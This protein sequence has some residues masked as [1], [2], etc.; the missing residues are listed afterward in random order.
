MV[1]GVLGLIVGVAAGV[2]VGRQSSSKSAALPPDTI[3]ASNRAPVIPPSS[4][5]ALR[6]RTNAIPDASASGRLTVE[7]LPA[8]IERVMRG[9]QMDRYHALYEL[10]NRVEPV[11]IPRALELLS[12]HSS[13]EVR[14]GISQRLIAR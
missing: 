3:I 12:K 4:F 8:A 10:A 1:F 6:A 7:D 9:S 13:Q 2:M 14:Y 5:Q 11:D